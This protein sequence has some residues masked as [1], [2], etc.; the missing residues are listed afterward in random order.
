MK[1]NINSVRYHIDIAGQ[2]EPLLL[3]HGF[4]GSMENWQP[5]LHEWSSAY[6]LVRLDLPGHGK[7]DLPVEP[8]R[9]AI[10][11]IAADIKKILEELRITKT[12]I[13]GY[14]M[15]GRLALTFA[16]KYPEH[17]LSLIVESGSPGLE[18]R[19]ERI[20]RIKHD[21]LLADFIVA[22]GMEAFVD[23]WENQPLFKTQHSLPAGTRDSI[24]S[25]RL[26]NYPLGLANSLRGMGSGK[27]PPL[28]NS[29]Q[30]LQMPVFL[31]AGDKD[32]KFCRIA[33]KMSKNIRNVKIALVPA[34]GH[35]IHVEHPE[36]FG[37]MV[38]NFL[39]NV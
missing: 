6:R 38:M 2:G 12:H 16:V 32:E 3:L 37:K 35:A 31:I 7:S 18:T 17:V 4:T 26:N 21:E 13:L 33:E 36:I 30:L 9:Y 28:W 39:K 20:D 5:F 29:L 24:R 1:I 27:Q 11:K 15:G 8:S 23:Y 25:Q 34:S 19:R 22:A 10:E 14:S